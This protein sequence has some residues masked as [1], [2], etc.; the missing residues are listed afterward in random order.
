MPVCGW[1]T[2]TRSGRLGWGCSTL[3]QGLT[4]N[5]HTV[6]SDYVGINFGLKV[7]DSMMKRHSRRGD[8]ADTSSEVSPFAA[9]SSE[10]I[11]LAEILGGRR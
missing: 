5:M 3:P 11:P 2:C 6:M 9:I 1:P 7:L 4:G 10:V 8:S